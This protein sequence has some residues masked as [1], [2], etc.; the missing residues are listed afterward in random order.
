MG[1][2]E[3]REL[4]LARWAELINDPSLHDVPY[5]IELNDQGVIEMSP[6][7]NAHGMHQGEIA[8]TLRSALPHGRVIMECSVLTSIGVRVPDVAWATKEFLARQGGNTPFTQAPEICV[9]IRSPSNTE[10]ALDRKIRAYLDVG[11]IEA[12]IV[13]LDGSVRFFSRD[14]E[15]PSSRF[16]VIYQKP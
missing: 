11:A 10:Q 15:L 16:G 7:S 3:S 13:D 12:W 5:K 2:A 8:W 4:L 6:A 14:G 9:E 1:H